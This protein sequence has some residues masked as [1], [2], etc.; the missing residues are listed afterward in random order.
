MP[1]SPTS[2]I[3]HEGAPS[4]THD[5]RGALGQ[6]VG[7]VALLEMDGP[8]LSVQR[9]EYLRMIRLASEQAL[10]KIAALRPP[11]AAS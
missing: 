11:D 7:L 3:A 4:L 2:R 1:D 9:K 10:D 5:L 6:I 8:P